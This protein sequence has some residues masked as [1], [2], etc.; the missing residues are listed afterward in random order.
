[1]GV[2][3]AAAV[4]ASKALADKYGRHEDVMAVVGHVD[5]IGRKLSE[6]R[7]PG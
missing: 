7:N 5:V 6:V 2:D 3:V 1:L 4:E